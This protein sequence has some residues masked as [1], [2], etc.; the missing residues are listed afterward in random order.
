M[1]VV[2]RNVMEEVRETIRLDK[3]FNASPKR[4]KNYPILFV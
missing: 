1:F 4:D 3:D 2:D